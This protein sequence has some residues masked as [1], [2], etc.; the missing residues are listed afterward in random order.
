MYICV[1]VYVYICL[2]NT[3]TISSIYPYYFMYCHAGFPFF[4]Q[5]QRFA[6]AVGIGAKEEGF[7][8]STWSPHAILGQ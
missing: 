2:L 3:L 8:G 1:C 4:L 5:Q 7:C 6:K